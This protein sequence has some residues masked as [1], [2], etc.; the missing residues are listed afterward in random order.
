MCGG[1][2]LKVRCDRGVGI[3]TRSIPACA[4]EPRRERRRRGPIQVYPRV[5][6]GTVPAQAERTSSD[7]LSPRVRGN[8][9]CIQPMQ[10][11]MRSIPACAGE[12]A[13]SRS[14]PASPSV[15]PRVCGG[16]CFSIA[17]VRFT[18]GLSPRVRG[19]QGK[20]ESLIS[21]RGSIPACA[22]EPE[23]ACRNGP[24]PRVYPRVCG[25]TEPLTEPTRNGEG[26]SPRVR[27]NRTGV[28]ADS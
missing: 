8:L 4:G 28:S 22:G 16:T 19:N 10:A 12:P 24:H 14:P 21:G 2:L 6:G 15:Y 5:C 20:T 17:S 7:G 27:G 18:S 9:R 3:Q 11:V 13:S 1:T 25:G 23:G 26:L